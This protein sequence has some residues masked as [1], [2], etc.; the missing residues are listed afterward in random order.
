MHVLRFAGGVVATLIVEL[1]AFALLAHSVWKI[2]TREYKK[3]GGK[4]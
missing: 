3:G 4:A 1:V 2:N